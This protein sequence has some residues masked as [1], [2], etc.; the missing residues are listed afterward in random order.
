MTHEANVVPISAY[1]F[2]KGAERYANSV[3]QRMSGT[4]LRTFGPTS[5]RA[6]RR[7][8]PGGGREPFVDA[9]GLEAGDRLHL[10]LGRRVNAGRQKG[11]AGTASLRGRSRV[12]VLRGPY[13]LTSFRSFAGSPD[14]LFASAV[15]LPPA[16]NTRELLE[17]LHWST[18]TSASM[19][20][21]A[22]A[23]KLGV[24]GAATAAAVPHAV[25]AYVWLKVLPYLNV[26]TCMPV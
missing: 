22:V 6:F 19:L 23:T 2:L 24:G 18:V 7:L 17:M 1:T 4:P 11:N 21:C 12:S 5:P 16:V 8:P 25:A 20:P 9:Q 10:L 14:G 15:Q 13:R 26:S 3:L